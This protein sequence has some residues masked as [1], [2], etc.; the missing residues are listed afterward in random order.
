MANIAGQYVDQQNLANIAVAG[1][2]PGAP[3]TPVSHETKGSS[4]RDR[5]EISVNTNV[6]ESSSN[7]EPSTS[8]GHAFRGNNENLAGGSYGH[9]NNTNVDNSGNSHDQTASANYDIASNYYNRPVNTN[10]NQPISPYGR[11]VSPT[12]NAPSSTYGST[13]GSTNPEAT[14]RRLVN[15]TGAASLGQHERAG[16]SATSSL[17]SPRGREY[18]ANSEAPNS[19]RA[20]TGNPGRKDLPGNSQSGSGGVS[21]SLGRLKLG[22]DTRGTQ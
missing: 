3:I 2:S 17:P 1:N 7:Y 16:N 20:R 9:S 14:T 18:S 22:D 6:Q 5:R 12:T 11:A 15:P 21:E 4:K 8:Y 19:P 10:V 13:Y